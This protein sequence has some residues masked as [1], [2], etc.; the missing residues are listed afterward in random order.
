MLMSKYCPKEQRNVI[1]LTCQE[2]E[3][4]ICRTNVSQNPEHAQSHTCSNCNNFQNY[5]K[6]KI[7]NSEFTA[8]NCRVYANYIFAEES[9]KNCP[10][11]GKDLSNEMICLNCKYF[12]GG[13]DWGLACT[14]YYDKLPKT[15]SPACK[16]FKR[17]GD[18]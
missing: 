4:K 10:Y 12:L 1:Y 8:V 13:S 9:K 3:D 11:F 2:C 7:G 16:D 14:M 5:I 17:K 18:G 6:T 15:L